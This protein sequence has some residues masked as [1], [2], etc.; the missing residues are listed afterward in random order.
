VPHTQIKIQSFL[1]N[2]PLF[3]ELGPQEIERIAAGARTLRA[4]RGETL[5]RKG[6]PSDGFYAI[7]FGQIKLAFNA[8]NGAEKVVEL[9]GSN[10]TFGEAVMFMERPYPVYAQA[11]ADSLLL[12]VSKAVVFDEIE[13]DPP[14]A[15][16]MIGGLARRLHGLVTDLEAYTLHSGTQRV[17]GY[18]LRGIPENEPESAPVEISLSTSKSILASRLNLTP[19]HFSRILHDLTEAGLI[20]VEGRSIRI[21]DPGALRRYE[22]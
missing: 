2:L 11:L 22:G 7:V 17:L 20:R 8:A 3:R 4:A 1:A 16:K 5:F 19:E 14:F 21:L 9:L 15:R 6:D 13:R 10:Q 12:H 18:L